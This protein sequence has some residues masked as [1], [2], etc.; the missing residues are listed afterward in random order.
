M[1]QFLEATNSDLLFNE[2]DVSGWDH[3][4]FSFLIELFWIFLYQ[5]CFKDIDL[6]DKRKLAQV[7]EGHVSSFF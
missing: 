6:N 3:R 5:N 4:L 1:R 7:I 2:Q